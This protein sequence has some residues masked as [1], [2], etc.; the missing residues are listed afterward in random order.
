M[1][2][3]FVCKQHAILISIIVLCL[4]LE[5]LLVLYGELNQYNQI[6]D[7]QSNYLHKTKMKTMLE[8][9]SFVQFTSFL[10]KRNKC[11]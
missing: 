2:H 10:P 4:F 3:D 7:Y 9:F 1:V 11:N 6:S 8:H 5:N